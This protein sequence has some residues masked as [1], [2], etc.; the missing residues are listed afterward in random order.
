MAQVPNSKLLGNKMLYYKHVVWQ[1]PILYAV[2]WQ[3]NYVSKWADPITFSLVRPTGFMHLESISSVICNS[4]INICYGYYHRA[5]HTLRMNSIV[6]PGKTKSSLPMFHDRLNAVRAGIFYFER[7]YSRLYNK[8]MSRNWMRDIH[9]NR[10]V[11]SRNNLCYSQSQ[12]GIEERKNGHYYSLIDI[13]RT[14][15]IYA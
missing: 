14:P 1:H 13:P 11:W 8:P 5:Y 4:M 15:W 9:R 3:V 6:M 2:W 10:L 7:C 12:Y